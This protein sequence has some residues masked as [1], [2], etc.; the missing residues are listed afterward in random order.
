MVAKNTPE[1]TNARIDGIP[2]WL[3]CSAWLSYGAPAHSW[4]RRPIAWLT[5]LAARWRMPRSSTAASSASSPSAQWHQ[6]RAA[7]RATES[8]RQREAARSR[9]RFTTSA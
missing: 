4:G 8:S 2:G 3:R 6:R 5:I 9:E 1:W 7:A